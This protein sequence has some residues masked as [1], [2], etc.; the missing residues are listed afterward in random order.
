LADTTVTADL[1]ATTTGLIQRSAAAFASGVPEDAGMT[2]FQAR[3][4]HLAD[5]RI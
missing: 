3:Q 5:V 4:R 1:Y 2:A